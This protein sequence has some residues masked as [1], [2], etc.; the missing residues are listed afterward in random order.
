MD[1]RVVAGLVGLVLGGGAEV[2]SAQS[3]PG[4]DPSAQPPVGLAPIPSIGE[5]INSST[6]GPTAVPMAPSGVP[7]NPIGSGPRAAIPRPPVPTSPVSMGPI[8]PIHQSINRGS[9]MGRIASMFRRPTAGPSAPPGPRP[10]IFS[11]A[12]VGPP[13]SPSALPAPPPV[14]PSEPGPI[15]RPAPYAGRSPEMPRAQADPPSNSGAGRPSPLADDR[16]RSARPRAEAQADDRGPTPRPRAEA[17]NPPTYRPAEVT[18]VAGPVPLDPLTPPA[19]PPELPPMAPVRLPPP[20]AVEAPS[21]PP[22]AANPPP[23]GSDPLQGV[24]PI[25]AIAPQ[26]PPLPPP[27]EPAAPDPIRADPEVKRTGQDPIPD[28]SAL[29]LK[30]PRPRELPYATRRAAAVGDEIITFN[31]LNTA[32]NE[33]LKDMVPPQ[34]G[35]M[36]EAEAQQLRQLKNQVAASVLNRLIDQSLIIQEAKHKLSRN[37]KF[38]QQ[39]NEGIEKSWK[40][41]EVPPL[42]RKYASANVHE[43]KIKLEA[44]GKSYDAMKAVFRK[45]ILSNEF[46]RAE[47]RNKLTC[48]VPEM[49]AYYAEHL[50]DFEQP[51]R[52]TWREVEISVARYPDRPTAREKAEDVLARLLRDE[53]FEAVAKSVS[54]GPTASKGGIYVDM[55]P[56][57]Y[58]IP[59]VNDELNRL[60]I[61]E[62]SADP[63]SPPARTISSGSTPDATRGRSGLMRC[64]TRSAP[65]FFEHNFQTGR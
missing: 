29:R 64:K 19:V 13:S 5:S 51:A 44:E 62:V 60:P 4:R 22:V 48:D 24:E 30:S 61:G 31:E 32:V 26:A 65:M 7:T 42:L 28:E 20:Q 52:M 25:P 2:G 38:E 11:P 56:G 50:K 40:A 16:P 47:I 9:G 39:F 18:P 43:L 3:L 6:A 12:P 21:P 49:R 36:S 41:D 63:G 14:E 15:G 59:V 54:N 17:S 55:Q 58:G 8:E 57:S 1:R 27:S 46:L 37:A 35:P 23:I 34:Q 45:K 53:D 33:Q 10:M